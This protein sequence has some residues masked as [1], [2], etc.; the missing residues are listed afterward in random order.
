MYFIGWYNDMHMKSSSFDQSLLLSHTGKTTSILVICHTEGE[1][2]DDYTRH[3]VNSAPKIGRVYS[4]LGLN[5]LNWKWVR[6]CPVGYTG[7]STCGPFTPCD[8][9]EL[10]GRRS[11]KGLTALHGLRWIFGA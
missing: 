8:S 11:P 2:Q 6:P 9:Y 10:Q 5:E 7:C 3:W 4:S 1:N